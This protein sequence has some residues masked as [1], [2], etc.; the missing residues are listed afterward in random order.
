M[1][2]LRSGIAVSKRRA[3]FAQAQLVQVGLIKDE[4]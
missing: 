4:K 2:F 1:M 3:Y